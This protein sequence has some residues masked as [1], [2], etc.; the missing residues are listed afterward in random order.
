MLINNVGL[1]VFHIG[2]LLVKLFK[3]V[4]NQLPAVL[5]RR[6][7]SQFST[8]D[9]INRKIPTINEAHSSLRYHIEPKERK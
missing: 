4:G 8:P 3:V 7:K 5:A 2:T 6:Y 9:S 1:I